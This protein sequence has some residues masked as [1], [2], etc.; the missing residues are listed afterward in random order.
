MD[1]NFMELLNRYNMLNHSDEEDLPFT[2]GCMD[3]KSICEKSDY[4][5]RCMEEEMCCDPDYDVAEEDFFFWGIPR[6][7]RIIFN[8]PATIVMW[9]DG[10]KTV[11]RCMK[12]EKFEKYAGFAAACLKKMFGSTS[13]A[14]SIVEAM[15][16]DQA[17]KRQ[18][19]QARVAQEDSDETLNG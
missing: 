16:V 6:I 12:G 2:G 17:E 15:S 13:F 1:L 19:K 11:V 3:G 10:T 5:D 4:F 8:D 18:K 14:K 7:S 9:D